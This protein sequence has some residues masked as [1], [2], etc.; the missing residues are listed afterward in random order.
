MPLQPKN[1]L[2]S[3]VLEEHSLNAKH[4]LCDK[5][6]IR[7]RLKNCKQDVIQKNQTEIPQGFELDFS[8]LQPINPQLSQQP[9]MGLGRKYRWQIGH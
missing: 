8:M 2:T 1:N 3:G 6:V 5:Y 9:A 7:V 4:C